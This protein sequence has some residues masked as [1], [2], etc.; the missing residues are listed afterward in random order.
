MARINVKERTPVLRTHEGAPAKRISPLF[1]LRRLVLTCMLWEDLFY[2][3]GQT[4]AEQIEGAVKAVKPQEAA[5]VALEART[6]GN[7]RHAPLLVA[8]V[9]AKLESHR[10]KV[11]AVLEK[12]IQRADELCEFLAIYRKGNKDKISAQVKK[13]LAKAF[14]KFDEYALAKYNRDG[15]F[16]LKDA[17]FICHAKPKD[18]DQAKLWKKLIGGYCANCWEK[19]SDHKP[20]PKVSKKSAGKRKTRK[21]R[22]QADGPC[23]NYV[24]AKLAIPDT[25]ETELSAGKDKKE[26]FTDSLQKRSWE[27]LRSLGISEI[28][29]S[30]ES[31]K[32][33]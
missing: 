10:E 4:V 8:R 29:K 23:G 22:K 26:T 24:P 28:W 12:I 27:V 33:R 20:E 13:G 25:W 19:E 11:A 31:A 7:L 21:T 6:I 14:T 32:K 3:D 15:E 18:E 9:M 2:V 17:L 5:D 30:Q 1:Q 16:K